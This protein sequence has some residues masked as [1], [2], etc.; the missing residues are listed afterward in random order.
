M[1]PKDRFYYQGIF[2]EDEKEFYKA[3]CQYGNSKVS[4]V[5]LEHALI[6]F[7]KR[8]SFNVFNVFSEECRIKNFEMKEIL[9]DMLDFFVVKYRQKNEEKKT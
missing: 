7:N 1:E 8:A 4:P 3:V 6:E 2:Y 5:S 9:E